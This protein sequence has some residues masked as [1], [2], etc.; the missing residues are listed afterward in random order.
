[1]TDEDRERAVKE[2]TRH[3]GDGRLTL[4]ELEDR[5]TEVYAATTRAQL[6]RAFRELPSFRL[7]P[8]EPDW[9]SQQRSRDAAAVPGAT[10]ARRARSAAVA[11]CGHRGMAK[12]P[13]F[14][15]ALITVLFVTAHFFWAVVLVLFVLPKRVTRSLARA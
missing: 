12:P 6:D 11:R 1:M 10:P 5:I 4:E 3:C 14:L 9:A 2:L 8:A 7:P 15:I 13:V